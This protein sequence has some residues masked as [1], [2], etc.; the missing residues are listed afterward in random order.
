MLDCT[1]DASHQEQMPLILR[2]VDKC[3]NSYKVKEFYIELLQV[4]DITGLGLFKVF[5]N[6]LISHDLDI[7][8]IRGQGYDNGFNMEENVKS[9]TLKSLSATRWESRVESIKAIRF[10]ILEIREALLEV[11]EVDDADND[12]K[13]QSEARPLANNEL[14]SFEF[15]LATIIWYEI[16][17]AVNFVSKRLQSHDMLIDIAIG[18]IKGLI[19][20]LKKYRKN[21]FSKAMDIAKKLDI[22]IGIDL[23]HSM[24]DEKLLS[25][26]FNFENALKKGE[27]S[28]FDGDDLFVE[29]T[30]FREF[31]PK[32]KVGA[33]DLSNFLKRYTCFPNATIAY[34]ILLTIPIT[35]ASAERSFSKLK[36]LKLY[37]RTTM[38]QERLNL[39]LTAIESDLLDED[40]MENII[41]DFATKHARRAALF[42]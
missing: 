37:L 32:E 30:W 28:D 5:K 8:N 17:C 31:L 33:I 12:H 7:D 4:N 24:D 9:L 36:L 25:S 29:L 38:S 15:L 26:C 6:V 41:D 27:V 1:P 10:Q 23:L 2:C 19:S 13:L 11:A 42:K 40:D 18:E 3:S 16:L 34:R 22:E 39:A 21:G 35:F 14:D 20:F